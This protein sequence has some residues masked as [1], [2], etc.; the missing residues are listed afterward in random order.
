M[1]L[2]GNPKMIGVP[3]TDRATGARMFLQPPGIIEI[4]E[5]RGFQTDLPSRKMKGNLHY[6]EY[7]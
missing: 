5:N 4:L 3:E 6:E 1:Y 7:W 2:C